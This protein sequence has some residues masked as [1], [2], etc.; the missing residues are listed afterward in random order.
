[1]AEC[2]LRNSLKNRSGY[3]RQYMV[4]YIFNFNGITVAHYRGDK[5]SS[6]KINRNCLLI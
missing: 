1:M 6:V 5:L 3:Y 4:E 2:Y